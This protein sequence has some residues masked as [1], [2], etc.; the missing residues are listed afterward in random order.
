M[1]TQ[2]LH[3]TEHDLDIMQ[4]CVHGEESAYTCKTE[5]ECPWLLCDYLSFGILPISSPIMNT[6][7]WLDTDEK[8]SY[9]PLGM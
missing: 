4:G 7:F 9:L 8:S 6:A 5:Y 1:T 2:I 3:A